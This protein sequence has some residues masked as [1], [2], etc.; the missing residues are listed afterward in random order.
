MGHARAG[1]HPFGLESW[2]PAFAGMKGALGGI[3]AEID[4][5]PGLGTL[6]P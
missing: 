1:G 6:P 5:L 4:A 3:P 2:I